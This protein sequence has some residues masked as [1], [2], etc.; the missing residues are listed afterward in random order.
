MPEILLVVN[1]CIVR[2]RLDGETMMV[3]RDLKG[4]RKRRREEESVQRGAMRRGRF[5]VRV[6]ILWEIG[7]TYIPAIELH[8][9]WH[10]CVEHSCYR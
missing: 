7:D 1:K 8:T 3:S 10:L 6:Q 9:T 2:W 4:K 5:R